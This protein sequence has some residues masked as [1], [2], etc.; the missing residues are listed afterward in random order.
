MRASSS[1]VSTSER[2]DPPPAAG[3]APPPPCDE[4]TPTPFV[5][6][7]APP[8]TT[9]DCGL[10]AA[11]FEFCLDVLACGPPPHAARS[12][13]AASAQTRRS[14][15]IFEDSLRR[16]RRTMIHANAR[17]SHTDSGGRSRFSNHSGAHLPVWHLLH[18]LVEGAFIPFLFS[19][20]WSWQELQLR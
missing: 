9:F 15:R 20:A 17:R 10:F 3:A 13:Q 6:M 8:A 2:S 4:T 1:E 12:A 11:E 16:F 19:T 7:F 5:F 18:S 14:F